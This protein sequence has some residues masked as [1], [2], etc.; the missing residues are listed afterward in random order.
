LTKLVAKGFHQIHGID[1]FET[2]SPVVKPV[3]IR[4][5][6]TLAP[7]NGCSIQQIDINNAFLN[8]LL[9]EDVYMTQELGFES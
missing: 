5:V 9:L 3:T 1:F 8:E 4:V 7:S 6:L 2:F